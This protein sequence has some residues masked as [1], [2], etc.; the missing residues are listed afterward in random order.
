[1]T[2]E[3]N[4]YGGVATAMRAFNADSRGLRA[5][6][7]SQLGIGVGELAAMAA[8]AETPNGELTPK[9]LA[10]LLNITTS[11]VTAMIDRLEAVSLAVRKPHPTDR[12][13]ILVALTLAGFQAAQWSHGVLEEAL[14]TVYQRH[15]GRDP[16]EDAVFLESA[17]KAFNDAVL[18]QQ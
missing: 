17:S 4:P 18:L 7:A 10:G 11:S 6:L 1:M 15:D 3:H 14:I 12:R 16:L 8:V 13:S 5:S 2:E 9:E